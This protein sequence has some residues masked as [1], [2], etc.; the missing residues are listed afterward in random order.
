MSFN[1]LYLILDN[2]ILRLKDH[3]EIFRKVVVPP[4]CLGIQNL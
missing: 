3:G 4:W 2:L 1:L